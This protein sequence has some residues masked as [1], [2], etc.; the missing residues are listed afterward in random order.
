[1]IQLIINTNNKMNF[2][3]YLAK[4]NSKC[5]TDLNVY[6]FAIIDPKLKTFYKVT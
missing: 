5:I 3:F 4:T 2:N 6:V 1:M